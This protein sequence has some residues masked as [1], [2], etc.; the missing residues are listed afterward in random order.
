MLS[1]FNHSFTFTVLPVTETIFPRVRGF[2]VQTARPLKR[3]G[4]WALWKGERRFNRR[5]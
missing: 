4:K 3:G 1:E 5:L 2:F